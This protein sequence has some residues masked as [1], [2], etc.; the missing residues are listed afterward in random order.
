[1]AVVGIDD[2]DSRT[3]GMCTTWIATE[4][5]R[6][7]N[8]AIQGL[9]L[10]RLNPAVEHK[11]RGN[12]AVAIQAECDLSELVGT[13]ESVIEEF[14]M[15]DDPE[16]NP[17]VTGATDCEA[18]TTDLRTF[19]RDAVRSI[20]RRRDARALLAAEGLEASTWGNGRGV[21][22][23]TAAIGAVACASVDDETDPV[24][25]DWTFEWLAYREPS[26]WGSTRSVDVEDVVEPLRRW[27]GVVWDTLDPETG[28]AVCAPNSPCPVLYGIRGDDPQGVEE[29][30]TAIGGEPVD[31]A[32][33][34]ATN[35]GTDGHIRPGTIGDLRDKRAYR[36]TGTVC[37]SPATGRG[38][39]VSF[40]I[41]DGEETLECLAFAPTGRFRDRVRE[42]VR[43]DR[44]LVCG[45]FEEGA[46]KLEKFAL[47]RRSLTTRVTPVCPTCERTLKSAGHEQGYRC[48]ECGTTA[49]GRVTAPR[50]RGIAEGWYEVP[51]EARRH[52]AKPLVRGG[53]DLPA[54]SSSV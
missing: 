14:A 9:F 5:A 16:T 31:R 29:V 47:L 32:H 51:P 10:V 8:S 52:L 40:T 25:G 7:V 12:G 11:T 26:R 21:I 35:Q 46:L 43:G 38:G 53:V 27:R 24:F 44:V 3:G 39:H 23:A 6:R 48:R 13:A 17:G 19:A 4:V 22:G 18:L 30:A 20:H 42:L 50:D 54:H 15:T 28:R 37:N 45:E 34:F 49:P 1:M 2:T 41:G 36:V 33:L